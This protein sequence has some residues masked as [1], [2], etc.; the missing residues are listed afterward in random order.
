MYVCRDG[1]GR[2][3]SSALPADALP[4]LNAPQ[5]AA[6]AG[7]T[8]HACCAPGCPCASSWNGEPNQHCCITCRN[9]TPC[10]SNYHPKP[11]TLAAPPAAPPPMPAP[12]APLPAPHRGQG[13]T[14]LDESFAT[15]SLSALLSNL[16][17]P[18]LKAAL[19]AASPSRLDLVPLEV[20]S[21]L[22]DRDR[23]PGA[24]YLSHIDSKA[25]YLNFDSFSGLVGCSVSSQLS[26][27]PDDVAAPPLPLP[28]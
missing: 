4:N 11:F 6:N 2:F 26:R 3:V 17:D 22:P 28:D 16:T 18:S 12:S 7:S 14:H 27:F 15:S 9:G 23:A 5:R 20:S 21:L 25:V 8:F 24:V 10:K 1:P 13:A 19:V